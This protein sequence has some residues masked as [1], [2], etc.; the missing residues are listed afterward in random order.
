M[1]RTTEDAMIMM[2]SQKLSWASG[3]WYFRRRWTVTISVVAISRRGPLRVR[4]R[5]RANVL[6]PETRGQKVQVLAR[7]KELVGI[8]IRIGWGCRGVACS[9]CRSEGRYAMCVKVSM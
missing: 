9:C 3:Q 5:A 2:T 7:L 6:F 8:A 1:P 4:A